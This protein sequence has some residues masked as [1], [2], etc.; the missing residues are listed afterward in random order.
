[1]QILATL[2]RLKLADDTLIVFSS[3]NGGVVNPNN[4]HAS[5]A[6]K[7]GLAIN[8]KLRG[9]K[10][11]VWEGGFREPFVVRWP[12]K[13]PAG[14]VCDDIVCLSDVLATLAGIL[15][16]PLPSGAAEDSFDL[17]TSWFGTGKAA[18]QTVVLQD[19]HATYALRQG[20]WKLV[21]RE[22]PPEF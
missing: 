13:V 3:D 14:T 4:P 15:S 22:Q 11:D 10:H 21:E 16:V 9:G 17:G 2:D 20:P 1:G 19:A 7:L 8:G 12:G 6:L 5:E 18:R